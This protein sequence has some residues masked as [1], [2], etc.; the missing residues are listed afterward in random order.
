MFLYSITSYIKKKKKDYLHALPFPAPAWG[1]LT[2]KDCSCLN[3]GIALSSNFWVGD[4]EHTN[5]CLLSF[6]SLPLVTSGNKTSV[7]VNLRNVFEFF[8]FTKFPGQKET[9]DWERIF[10][11]FYYIYPGLSFKR[12]SEQI[13]WL[14]TRVL[15]WT[16]KIHVVLEVSLG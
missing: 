14:D 12:Y 4:T 15:R 3:F 5:S 1:I 13:L 16:K 6:Y 8:F 7:S 10:L 9:K 2:I 11:C